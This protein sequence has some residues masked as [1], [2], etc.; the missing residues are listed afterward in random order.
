[1]SSVPDI[2][3]WLAGE[4]MNADRMNEIKASIDFLRNPPMVHVTRQTTA[5]NLVSGWNSISFDTVVNSYDPYTMF[6]AAQP[7]KVFSQVPGWYQILGGYSINGTSTEE[8]QILGLYKNGF[9]ADE[10]QMRSDVQNFPSFGNATWTKEF[11]VFLN[12]GDWMQ[13]GV[14]FDNDASRTTSTASSTGELC[15]LRMRWVSS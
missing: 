3:H 6:D 7:T 14:W 11:T 2:H 15:R 8:R 10:L 1:M 9:T 4:D 12:T 13:L 5:Q